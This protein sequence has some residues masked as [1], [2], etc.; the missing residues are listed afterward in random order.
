VGVEA[1]RA[2]LL[3]VAA[4][5]IF[6]ALPLAGTADRPPGRDQIAA[7]ELPAEQIAL[8]RARA[9]GAA[10]RAWS[11]PQAWVGPQQAAGIGRNPFTLVLSIGGV[12]R[13]AGDVRTHW[14]AGWEVQESPSAVRE[15]L[16]P[17][18][19]LSSGSVKPGTPLTL[20]SVGMPVS[21][22]GERSAAPMLSLVTAHNFEIQSVRVAVWSGSAPWLSVVPM[23]R[24]HVA[25]LL[26]AGLCGAAWRALRRTTADAPAAV[27]AAMA[28]STWPPL[29][30]RPPVEAMPLASTAVQSAAP[31]SAAPQP[32][33]TV[34]TPATQAARVV[35]ALGEVL[36]AAGLSVA[37]EFDHTRRPRRR[38]GS[39][40]A[41]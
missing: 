41:G 38:R 18:A 33:V 12:A 17:V 26:L 25:A 1:V 20:R 3:L 24:A 10:A 31:P 29:A 19:A 37:T 21:F 22:R 30:T 6:H 23:T 39:L 34:A 32:P 36:G 13:S 15:L 28:T 27:P 14:H 16:L 9:D 11:E 40:H 5:A 8:Y 4:F 7:Y 35:A 2:A